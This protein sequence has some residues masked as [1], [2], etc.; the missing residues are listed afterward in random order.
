MISR[1][2][3][4]EWR[5]C[6]PWASDAQVEQDLVISRAIVAIFSSPLLASSLAFRGGTALHKLYIQPS[7][8]FSE[9]I[10][11][12]RSIHATGILAILQ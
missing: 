2:Y 7:G 8:R 5:A 1:A 12:T 6:T 4:S 10:F 9:D 3:I 11:L